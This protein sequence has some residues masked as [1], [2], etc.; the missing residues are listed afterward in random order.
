[1]IEVREL[2]KSYEGVRAVDGLSFRAPPGKVTAF[3]GPNGSG[4]STTFR[5]LLGLAAPDDGE[6]LVDGRRYR[7]LHSPRRSIGAV[8]ESTG[9]HPGRTGRDHLRVVT[10]AAGLDP[11]RIDTV[12]E[13]TG[14]TG[15]AGRRVGGYSLGM[16]QRLG[17]ATAMLGDPSVFVLDEPSNGLDPQ[18]VAWA[19][20]LLRTW[21]DDG[22]TVLVASH[23]L[24]EIA[25]VVDRVVVI[26]GGRLVEETDVTELLA[27]RVVVRV[28]DPDRMVTALAEH[29]ASH[30]RRDDSI[31]ITGWDTAEVGAL[32]AHAGVTV[33]HLATGTPGEAL[34]EM[35]LDLVG[36]AGT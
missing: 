8:L 23:V 22:R 28:D 20:Q 12:L 31:V 6:V 13:L 24:A 29:D 10:R 15:A 26:R 9:H 1:V 17:L 34:E 11:A 33:T 7:D 19:R 32:A 36:E 35:F 27:S 2:T 5:C 16:R 21:A 18:G 14:L 30:Q 3:L 4:K 25:P